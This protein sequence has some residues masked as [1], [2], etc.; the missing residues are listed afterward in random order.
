MNSALA[1]LVC[2]KCPAAARKIALSLKEKPIALNKWNCFCI[3]GT[4]DKK[5]V[6]R[7]QELQ[8]Q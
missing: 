1:M 7:R 4:Q 3:L 8:Q 6:C 5:D 2:R